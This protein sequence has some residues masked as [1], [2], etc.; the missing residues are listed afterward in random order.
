MRCAS[1]LSTVSLLNSHLLT[2]SA[3]TRSGTV[4]SSSHSSA[5]HWSF[6]SSD[7][8]SYLMPSR[9][10]LS[11]TETALGGTRKPSPTASSRE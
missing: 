11:G 7:S 3:S 6:S 9:W 2:A 1:T 10:N 5:S 8:P 4:P